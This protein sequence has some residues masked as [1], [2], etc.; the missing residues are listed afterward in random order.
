MIRLPYIKALVFASLVSFTSYA[1]Q[2]MP[3]EMVLKL[4]DV[5]KKMFPDSVRSQ[6]RWLDEQKSNYIYLQ[7]ITATTGNENYLQDAKA[8]AK[9]KFPE[10]FTKQKEFVDSMNNGLALMDAFESLYAKKEEFAKRKKELLQKYP[11]DFAK[12]AEILQNE[13][14]ALQELAAVPCP[15]GVSR[16]V[17]DAFRKGLAIQFE[18]DFDRQKKELKSFFDRSMEFYAYQQSQKSLERDSD[19]ISQSD[20]IKIEKS[21]EKLADSVF[22]VNG[23]ASLG[24]PVTI[25]DKT[26]VIFPAEAY[27]PRGFSIVNKMDERI[28]FDTVFECADY[29]VMIAMI[30]SVSEDTTKFQLPSEEIMRGYLNKVGLIYSYDNKSDTILR[31]TPSSLAGVSMVYTARIPQYIASGSI[32]TDIDGQYLLSMAVLNNKF[33][34]IGQVNASEARLIAR[35]IR[36]EN[37]S[38]MMIRLDKLDGWKKIDNNEYALQKDILESI[39]KKNEEFLTF[40]TAKSFNELQSLEVFREIYVKYSEDVKSKTDRAMFERMIRDMVQVTVATMR[41][42]VA[43]VNVATFYS[44]L[45]DELSFNLLARQ[46]MIETLETSLKNNSFTTNYTFGLAPRR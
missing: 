2:E 20:S 39:K 45:R 35:D 5:A 36:R 41:R 27:N 25:Q 1:Q 14:L 6:D 3:A 17:F 8:Q 9:A 38:K 43:K 34:D 31:N 11:S 26:C 22:F 23:E 18:N 42:D 29:P 30:K 21:K 12:A 28:I 7:I 4:D 19:A 46:R 44:S 24:F 10:D 13:S 37:P 33:G 16:D 32:F 40:F 15:E